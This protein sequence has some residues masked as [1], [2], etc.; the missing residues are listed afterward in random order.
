MTK[1]RDRAPRVHLQMSPRQARALV[2][3]AAMGL[4]YHP[5]ATATDQSAVMKAK[6]QLE[7]FEAKRAAE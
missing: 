5:S 4:D 1:R 7:N 6:Q 3:L 2:L